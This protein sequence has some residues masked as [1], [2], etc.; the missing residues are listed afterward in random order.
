MNNKLNYSL[1]IIYKKTNTWWNINYL[2]NALTRYNNL[3]VR[4]FEVTEFNKNLI[5]RD[6]D[7]ITLLPHESDLAVDFINLNPRL[8]WIHC[9][10][11]GV[12]KFLCKK[13]ITEND[14][15]ILTNARGA[16]ADSLAEYSIFAMLY[17]SYNTDIYL[18]AFKNRKWVQP[19]NKM[20]NHKTLTIVGYGLNGL[21]LAKKAKLGFN[22][23]VL[24]I[25]KN[26]LNFPGKEYIDEIHTLDQLDTILP[27]TDFLVN[28]LP[29]TNETVNLFNYNKFRLMKSSSVFINIGRGSAVE[30][31]DLIK[32]LKER[33]IHGAALDVFKTEPLPS[34]SQLYELDNVLIS[35]HS[36]DNT[37][38]YFKQGVDVFIKNLESYINNQQLITVVDKIK[39][40]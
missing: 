21:Q 7:I 34:S 31:D 1:G 39:G 23:N 6:L 30:E 25:K 32:V 9:M 18:N 17:F 19:L 14:K 33:V 28:I 27:R 11:A 24:G 38:E 2:Q 37:D 20:I 10:W 12:D 29:Q 26:T 16:Y 3:N 40:Y 36:S 5:P 15:I 13:E 4:L 22:M 8:Q 35:N